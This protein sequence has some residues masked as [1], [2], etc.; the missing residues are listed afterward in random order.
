M[1]IKVLSLTETTGEWEPRY[2]RLEITTPKLW[3]WKRVE[4]RGARQSSAHAIWRFSDGIHEP[5]P[6]QIHTAIT[7][8]LKCHM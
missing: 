1:N 2:A 6:N 8:Y 7:E 3:F 5:V 4:I